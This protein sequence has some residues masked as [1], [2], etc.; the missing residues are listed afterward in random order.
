MSKVTVSYGQTWLD[1]AMQE[2]GDVE[3]VMELVLLNGR[4]LSDNLQAGEVLKVPDYDISKR[5]FIQLF[6][7]NANK[8]AS[9]ESFNA[10]DAVAIG[11]GIEFWAIENDFV[12]S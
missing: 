11:E 1:I 9:G 4:S 8:P 12:V 6:A 2:L 5:K 3:R 10:D 7:N